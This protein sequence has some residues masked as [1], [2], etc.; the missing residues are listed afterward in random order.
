MTRDSLFK[1]LPP[2]IQIDTCGGYNFEFGYNAYLDLPPGQHT[3]NITNKHCDSTEVI[4]EEGRSVLIVG[5]LNSN[6]LLVYLLC[7]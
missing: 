3:I 6:I 7:L 2:T 5:T 1:C 4:V